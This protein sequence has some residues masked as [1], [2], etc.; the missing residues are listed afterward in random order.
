MNRRLFY[1]LLLLAG[2]AAVTP[3]VVGWTN[4]WV[5]QYLLS[6]AERAM[7]AQDYEEAEAYAA[8]RLARGPNRRASTLAG[9]AAIA[10]GRVDQAIEHFQPMLLESD[11]EAIEVIVAV[12]EL[13]FGKGNSTEAERL[14]KRALELAP[15]QVLARQKLA[16]LLTLQGRRRESLPIRF[17]LLK[18]G[19]FTAEDLCMLGNPRAL[20]NNA[21]VANF[22]AS[23]PENPMWWLARARLAYRN[24]ESHKAT[25]L[26]RN[27]VTQLPGFI[28]GQAGLGLALL[29][30]GT[31]AEFWNWHE[32]VPPATENHAD[33][34][35]VRGL[36]AQR[37]D[38]PEAA[39]RCFWEALRRES[40]YPLANY[41]LS[42]AL[43]AMGSPEDAKPFEEQAV[44]LRRLAEVVER[45]FEEDRDDIRTMLMAAEQTEQ[46]GRYWE[47]IG[48]H[49]L[50]LLR[51]PTCQQSLLATAR[52]GRRLMAGTPRVLDA[53]NPAT[54]VDFSGY[55]LP[56]IP[57][58]TETDSQSDV[59]EVAPTIRFEDMAKRSGLE[60]S[61]FNGEDLRTEGRRMFEFP[62]GGVAVLDYDLDG[63]PDIYFTQGCH[64]PRRDDQPVL[65][66]VLY[67][68]L[69]DG[70]FRD[71]TEE[72]GLGDELFGQGV[73]A[74]DFNG[75]GFP[76]LCVGNVG[77]NRLY[78]NNT[79][80]TFTEIA[81]M[82]ALGGGRWTTS[83]LIADLNGDGISD[84]FHV[85][86][87]A[88][89]TSEMLCRRICSPVQFDAEADCFLQG[90][91][92]GT[93]V[94]RTV[95]AGFNGSD[96]K[97][98]AIAAFDIAGSGRLAVFV[99][100]DTTAN[101]FYLND[102][103]R[104]QSARFTESALLRGVAFDR[105][106]RAQA[107]MGIGVNDA[108][109]DGRLD[110]F[111]GN[112]YEEFNAFFEQ[113][114]GGFFADV[115]REKGLSEPSHSVLTFG[116]E[117][118]DLD[119]DGF[120]DIVATNGHVD[121]FRDKGMPYHMTPHVY[122][123][124]GGRFVEISKT[125]GPFFQHVY[126]GRSVAVLDWNRDGKSDWVISHLDSPAALLENRTGPVGHHLALK[127]TGTVTERDAIGVTC[128]VTA[129]GRT[130]MQ[131]IVGG[132]GYHAS[133]E[134]QLL[135]GLGPA[136][137]VERIQIR[138]PSGLRQE[139]ENVGA[140]QT[141]RLIEGDDELHPLP[142]T[143]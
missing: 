118:A 56:K 16:H 9:Y 106:G 5:S 125:C 123:N 39:V 19:E 108:D 105:D 87:L 44:K 55:P 22:E 53:A 1:I 25:K 91:G 80:G 17:E 15:D 60:F 3:W 48:W 2:L 40:T 78:R 124:R 30:S 6:H 86:Y 121:D 109:G 14:F 62:G 130:M 134:K 27:I 74:G 93:F 41:Q 50:V 31:P 116:V 63:W 33:L 142:G 133:N 8:R 54:N 103:P 4:R 73:A 20:I 61:Y 71:V 37:H 132:S 138:W 122:H 84:V 113:M 89:N 75:D 128:W 107:C 140:D 51:V 95:E 79:D 126:L 141:Y 115:S 112:F 69:G 137:V 136:T 100:N 67:R 49:R 143:N 131:Q 90:R 101:F 99:A 76:D 139:F 59:S 18:S 92:D 114:P 127:F 26:F 83:C 57:R 77:P 28:D 58:P 64:W 85:N 46:L 66:D 42:V 21:E 35:V 81:G 32:R 88:G 7:E 47:A 129:A 96:G 104:G 38:Q 98:L 10:Q 13:Q 135:F 65:R 110:L 11:A 52:L 119:L 12:A 97:G 120:Q 70:R 72:A 24:S 68:N 23:D 82:V 43:I 102:R 117:F 94:D 36:W 111:I 34:W 45:L 29:D